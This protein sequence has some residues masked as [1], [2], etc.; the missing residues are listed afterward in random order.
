MSKLESAYGRTRRDDALLVVKQRFGLDPLEERVG[1]WVGAGFGLPGSVCRGNV[2]SSTRPYVK[3]S[4]GCS[5]IQL[6]L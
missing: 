6:W 4:L 1:G 5:T 2:R 3:Q